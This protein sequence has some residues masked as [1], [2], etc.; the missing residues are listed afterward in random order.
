M[1]NN[2]IKNEFDFTSINPLGMTFTNHTN[3][4]LCGGQRVDGSNDPFC[5]WL[6]DTD[7]KF[8]LKLKMPNRTR[9]SLVKMNGNKSCISEY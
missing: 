3:G 8:D 4:V 6:L 1:C 9:A 2:S 7:E 5:A